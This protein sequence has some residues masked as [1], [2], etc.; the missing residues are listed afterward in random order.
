[1]NAVDRA[2][3]LMM[4]IQFLSDKEAAIR[5]AADFI[6]AAEADARGKALRDAAWHLESIASHQPP[7][8]APPGSFG[9]PKAL[10][11]FEAFNRTLLAAAREIRGLASKREAL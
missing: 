10:A 11:E 2:R 9:D 1:M 8:N 3:D 4:A 7:Q 6:H 5:V